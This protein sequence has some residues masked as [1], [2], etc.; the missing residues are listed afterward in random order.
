M[1]KKIQKIKDSLSQV[2]SKPKIKR[3]PFTRKLYLVM[4]NISIQKNYPKLVQKDEREK[5]LFPL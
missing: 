2:T 1:R 3:L 5:L 4:T